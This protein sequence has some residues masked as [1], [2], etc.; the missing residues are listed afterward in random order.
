M[1][2][3]LTT[4]V[5]AAAAVG[6]PYAASTDAGR[7]MTRSVASMLSP[8]STVGTGDLASGH[9]HY[10]VESLWQNGLGPRDLTALQPASTLAASQSLGGPRVHDLR[11]VLRFD[12]TPDWVARHFTRVSTVLADMQLDGL[13]V[14]LVTGTDPQD[15]AGSVTYYFDHSGRMQRVSLHGFTGDCSRLVDTMQRYYHMAPEPTLDA[16]VYTVRWNGQP[17]GLLKVTRAPVMYA[18]ATHQRYT[19][20]LELNQ[21]D[22]R[23]G[24]SHAAQQIVA[25]DR[26]T[27]RW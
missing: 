14:P 27:G 12:I 3:R 4:A 1:P 25:A 20:F 8:V 7:E 9:G 22:I 24:L 11:D 15:L 23:Y 26:I 13:R 5:L 16:G 10:Q 2:R 19:V 17:T 18:D 21:P 6:G